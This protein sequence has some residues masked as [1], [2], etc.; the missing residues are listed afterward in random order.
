MLTKTFLNKT[1]KMAICDIYL[2]EI[3]KVRSHRKNSEFKKI[4]Q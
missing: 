2:M 1:K 4:L 3:W